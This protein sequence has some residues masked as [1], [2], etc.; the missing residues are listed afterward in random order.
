MKPPSLVTSSSRVG[1]CGVGV[2]AVVGV[3]I[4]KR[5]ADRMGALARAMQQ[6]AGGPT[7]DQLAAAQQLQG[8]LRTGG[9][10]TAVLLALA[11]VCMA[12]ARYVAF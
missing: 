12:A 8:R 9:R 10:I 11:V 3:G 4:Q 7:P 5:N 2:G 6:Q 1:P